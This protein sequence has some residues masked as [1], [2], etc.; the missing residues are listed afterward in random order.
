[1]RTQVDTTQIKNDNKQST[2]KP[3]AKWTHG[4]EMKLNYNKEDLRQEDLRQK[5]CHWTSCTEH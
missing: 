2:K 5:S 4:Y 1:M 3:Y